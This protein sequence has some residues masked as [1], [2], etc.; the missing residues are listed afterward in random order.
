MS[1]TNCTFHTFKPNSGKWKYSGRGIIDAMFWQLQSDY[2]V[3][4]SHIH[5]LNDGKFPGMSCP[6]QDLTFVVLPDEMDFGWPMLVQA[7]PW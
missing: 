2:N 4:A 1:E 3:R 7:E 6:V 5:L